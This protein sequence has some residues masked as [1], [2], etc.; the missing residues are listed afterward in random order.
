MIT[1]ADVDRQ[2][3]MQR[4]DAL[5]EIGRAD[6]GG[7]YRYTF[8]E[9]HIAATQMIAGWMTAAS[10]ETGY[11]RW[12][13][14]YGRT[15]GQGNKPCVMSGSH[16]DS[17]PNG[18]NYDGPLGVLTALEA[19]QTVVERGISLKRPLEV[20]S[21]IEEEGASFIGLLGSQ[22]ATNQLVDTIP[23]A[24]TAFD[25]TPFLDALH[26]ARLPTPTVPDLN[27]RVAS[28]VELHI[29][30]GKRL[31][32]AG[33][34]IGVVTAIAGPT[35]MT[36]DLQGKSDHAGATAYADRRD[37]LLAAAE[38]ITAVRELGTTRFDG[39]AHMTVGK[40]NAHPN[41]TNVVAGRTTFDIDYRAADANT[42]A[43]IDAALLDLIATI[44]EK[45]GLTYTHHTSQRVDPTAIP[46]HIQKAITDGASAAGIESTGI[47]SWAAH[48][49][50]IMNGVTD[51]GMIFVPCRDGRSHT[52]E[53]YVEPDDIAAG[54]AALTN[55][56]IA[57]AT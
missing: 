54:V 23:E 6:S 3:I 28:F 57:L 24:I 39:R 19:V 31:E 29:E 30:Q 5:A 48:D 25:G 4:L 22:L 41:V 50:M 47:I 43:E 33:I 35:F 8:S 15:R 14:L 12:G 40:I 42:Q 2:R 21:F 20:V 45:H 44:A 36:V 10:L 18:G 9:A 52:P 17:V 11:D 51:I 55:T 49:A 16:L 27:A 32:A 34:P 1:L 46:A 37:T 7:F 38:I 13:N 53:E 56:L 26:A